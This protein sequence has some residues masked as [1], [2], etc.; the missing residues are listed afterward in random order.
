MAV[1]VFGV[2]QAGE[3]VA[4]VAKLQ[5]SLGSACLEIRLHLHGSCGFVADDKLGILVV[6]WV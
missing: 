5:I 3:E 1:E 2:P 6:G 4:Y